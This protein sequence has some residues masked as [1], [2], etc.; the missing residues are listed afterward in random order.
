MEKSLSVIAAWHWIG[1]SG[2]PRHSYSI[3]YSTS[4]PGGRH[5]SAAK[6]RVARYRAL[7]CGC[8]AGLSYRFAWRIDETSVSLRSSVP[9]DCLGRIAATLRCS[10]QCRITAA[11]TTTPTSKPLR[12]RTSSE[13]LGTR[14]RPPRSPR[15]SRRVHMRKRFPRLRLCRQTIHPI[16]RNPMAGKEAVGRR[17]QTTIGAAVM[18]PMVPQ[19]QAV[20]LPKHFAT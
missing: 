20:V 19:T 2:V 3:R 1:T 15:R 11:L 17:H 18:V 5:P 14:R 6:L 7:L 10:L 9:V 4:G 8:R 16:R 13:I 12:R